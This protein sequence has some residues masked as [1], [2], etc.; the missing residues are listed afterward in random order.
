MFINKVFR[1]AFFTQASSEIPFIFFF[2]IVHPQLN[3]SLKFYCHNHNHPWNIASYYRRLDL[4]AATWVAIV[5][6]R[7]FA[8]LVFIHSDVRLLCWDL[9]TKAPNDRT[10]FLLRV[11]CIELM[12]I[13]KKKREECFQSREA[14]LWTQ[15]KISIIDH[16]LILL[17]SLIFIFSQYY[18]LPL[19]LL[20]LIFWPKLTPFGFLVWGNNPIG[21]CPFRAVS[22]LYLIRLTVSSC[23]VYCNTPYQVFHNNQ[24]SFSLEYFFSSLYT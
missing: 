15:F 7:C 24:C 11:N 6:K 12:E 13:M 9:S 22:E 20:Y 16:T 3:F 5:S 17:H 2:H 18:C 19:T 21:P 4:T 23:C 8:I 1:C 14:I 10:K